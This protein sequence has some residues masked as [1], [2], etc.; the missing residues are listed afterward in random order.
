MKNK[1]QIDIP[2]VPDIVKKINSSSLP[3]IDVFLNK[4]TR[5]NLKLIEEV[6][7]NLSR[8]NFPVNE[9]GKN[10][11]SLFNL[12]WHSSQPCHSGPDH[13]LKKCLLHGKE[14][15]CS[16][17]FKPVPT[18]MGVCCS[19]NH[20]NVLKD[21]EFS[22]LLKEKQ[23]ISG[24]DSQSKHLFQINYATLRFYQGVGVLWRSHPENIIFHS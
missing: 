13:L 8:A 21:S 5:A 11:S 15:D 7:R 1:T 23:N 3:A 6:M 2:P 16:K 17:L 10:H 4:T 12:L 9:I 24:E 18:D 19:F 22:K 14:V 20:R